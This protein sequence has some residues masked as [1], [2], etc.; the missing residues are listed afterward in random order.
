MHKNKHFHLHTVF[1]FMT[2]IGIKR[3]TTKVKDELIHLKTQKHNNLCTNYVQLFMKV[4]FEHCGHKTNQITHPH[5]TTESIGHRY[6][7]EAE[8]WGIGANGSDKNCQSSLSKFRIGIMAHSQRQNQ[9]NQKWLVTNDLKNLS[10]C[11]CSHGRVLSRMMR[12]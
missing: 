12:R 8:N 3:E 5:T 1:L 9:L 10:G 2:F 7:K 6:T 11:T 4:D